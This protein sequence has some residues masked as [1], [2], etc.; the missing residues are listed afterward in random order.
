ML[1]LSF[2]FDNKV[3]YFLIFLASS[4]LRKQVGFATLLLPSKLMRPCLYCSKSNLLKYLFGAQLATLSCV[5]TIVQ[6]GMALP[7]SRFLPVVYKQLAAAPSAKRSLH[8]VYIKA[9]KQLPRDYYF[10]YR[11]V[12]RLARANGLDDLPW[13]IHVAPK[14]NVN[15]Y[16]TDVNLIAVYRGMLDHLDGD[17]DALACVLGHEMAH[18]IKNH[19]AVTVEEKKNLEARLMNDAIQKV[20]AENKDLQA[21]LKGMDAGSRMAGAA[22]RVADSYGAK[23]IGSLVGNILRSAMGESRKRRLQDGKKTINAIVAK[24]VAIKKKEWQA[25]HHGNEFESDQLAYIYMV[26]AGFQPNGCFT[27]L[28]VL[29]RLNLG[30]SDTHPANADRISRLKELSMSTSTSRLVQQGRAAVARNPNPLTYDLSRDGRT[31]RINSAKGS[32]E[33]DITMPN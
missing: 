2:V 7:I 33:L 23:G 17:P 30:A 26:T 1:K 22:G 21:D 13:R 29:N 4:F 10:T 12:E 32:S 28:K 11:V 20:A 19:I 15:A 14:Y 27:M 9:K 31:L 18:H 5:L 8:P 25:L 16:A 6:P 24:Q 3:V